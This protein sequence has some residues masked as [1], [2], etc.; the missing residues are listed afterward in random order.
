MKT[1]IINTDYV[2]ESEKQQLFA[3]FQQFYANTNYKQFQADFEEKN[4]LIRMTDAGRLAGFSTQELIDLPIDGNPTRFLFS[5][6]TIVHPDYWQ[7]SHLAGAFGHLFQHI[8]SRT[9]SPLYWFL[10][11]K[12]FRTYRFLP[13]FFK[14]FHP[15]LSGNNNELK[16]LLDAIATHKFGSC[17]NSATELIEFE[18]TKDHLE[19]PF[20]EI[21]NNRNADAHID[22]FL[23][24][25]P[26]YRTG[27]ELAGI[28]PLTDNLTRCGN[29]VI[30]STQVEW[31]A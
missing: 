14:Q 8:Q 7:K 30:D 18:K 9:T 6:D 5:G 20:A 4:W 22:F 15:M 10:I 13:V 31:N 24:R 25:N 1:E 3:L 17:Y 26:N 11:S 27:T 16:P 29:R 19:G 21:P 2:H 12:G 23:R 28:A